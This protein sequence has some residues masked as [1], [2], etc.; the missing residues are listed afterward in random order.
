MNLKL[1]KA[2]KFFIYV[3]IAVNAGLFKVININ[4]L[5]SDYRIQKF[6]VIFS[7]VLYFICLC[8]VFRQTEFRKNY[9][10]FLNK[11]ILITVLILACDSLYTKLNYDTTF[12]DLISTV[13]RF[14]DIL[15]AYPII[16]VFWREKDINE[17]LKFIPKI[18]FISL[19]IRFIVWFMYNMRGIPVFPNILNEYSSMWV[20]DAY[21][22]ISDTSLTGI[23]FVILVYFCF[24]N[25]IKKAERM[26]MGFMA[27]FYVVYAGV[28]YASRSQLISMLMT[29][30]IMMIIKRSSKKGSMVKMVILCSLA[31]ALG[32]S[33]Y[34]YNL[35]QSFSTSS[36]YSLSTLARINAVKY[37]MTLWNKSMLCGIGV[38][39]T[40]KDFFYYIVH[41]KVEGGLT[42]YEDLGI[43]GFI[44]NFG[45]LG[46]IIFAVPLGRFFRTLISHWQ[47]DVKENVLLLGLFSY[48]IISCILSQSVFDPQRIFSFPFYIAIFEYAKYKNRTLIAEEGE[49]L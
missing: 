42:Y 38:L 6:T 32:G 39:N 28:V 2:L 35:F 1:S 31:A 17:I 33:S 9:K 15:L 45:L 25:R 26:L 14:A 30:F 23:S 10:G 3:L 48:L 44:F 11:Y 29:T 27:A 36:Q 24:D 46:I 19:A 34:L 37:Y 43:L 40:G 21:L 8:F 13:S 20:K 22:R 18:T 47:T 4:A 41:A 7:I 5:N 16:Y 12:M 49:A